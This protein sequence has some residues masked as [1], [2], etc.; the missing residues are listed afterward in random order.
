M[1]SQ[2]DNLTYL[3]QKQSLISPN[4][5]L[6]FTP[7]QLSFLQQLHQQTSLNHKKEYPTPTTL[8]IDEHNPDDYS[9][10]LST[11]FD[12]ISHDLLQCHLT[13]PPN[14]FQSLLL[15]FDQIINFLKL[16]IDQFIY[17]DY[18]LT[19]PHLLL[20]LQVLKQTLTLPQIHQL[21]HT[22]QSL[23][24]PEETDNF[25]HLISLIV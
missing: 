9:D 21:I 1:N 15:N 23:H 3:I 17:A 16:L 6:K 10:N 13:I 22:L 20:G 18:D 24:D 14:Y 25:Q 11:R 7:Q 2:L 5:L 12:Q 19:E 8:Y 4:E